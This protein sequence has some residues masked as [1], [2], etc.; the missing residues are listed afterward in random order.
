MTTLP[1]LSPRLARSALAWLAAALLAI[2]CGG[3][4][5]GGQ[6]GGA[7]SAFT[8]GTINGFGSVI[9]D[10]VRFEDSH[11]QVVDDDDQAHD[12]SELKLGMTVEVESDRVQVASSGRSAE[13]RHIRFGAEIVG[14][15]EA[16]D[17]ASQ[18]TVLGQTV[19]VSAT[20][21]FDDSLA[22]G[23]AALK[24]GDIV[25][26]HAQFNSANGHYLAKRIEKEAQVNFF[27]L[28]GVVAQ[29]D[30]TG[31]TFHIGGATISYRAIAAA[32]LPANFANGLPVRVRLQTT[33]VAGVWQAVNIR[34]GVRK[35]EDHDEAQVRGTVTAVTP[36]FTS[37]SVN[38]LPVTTS[39]ATAF[40][41]GTDGIE[42]GVAVEVEGA[43]VNGVLVATKVELED[44]HANDDDRMNELHGTVSTLDPQARTFVVRSVKVHYSDSTAFSRGSA[45]DLAEGKAVEVKGRLGSD[46]VTVEAKQIKFEQ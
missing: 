23:L 1:L 21:V 18:L 28:R 42:V 2:G 15:V 33:A 46:G 7:G 19:E 43:I 29:L 6:A 11:A 3:G 44:H 8:M 13:A 17:T 22:G 10:G 37:F 31:Q 40:P 12:R 24:Q 20:T 14:P 5:G 34:S 36:D 32:D 30:T 45:S 9:V 41:D 26:V 27:R 16:N 39:A 4:G 25:E 38:G 35:V